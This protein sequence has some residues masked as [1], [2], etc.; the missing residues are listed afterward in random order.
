[1]T[2]T[3]PKIHIIGAGISG[4]IAATVLENKGFSPVVIDSSDRAGGR[5]K[6]D[7]I[8][9]FQLDHGFQVLLSSYSAAQKYLDF[10]SLELQKLK[11]G[12]YIYSDGRKTKYGD[13]LR[14]LSMLVPT[15]FSKVGSFSDKLKIAKLNSDIKK[16]SVEEIFETNE[17]STLDY[18]T[19]YG[20]SNNIIQNFFRP[21]FSGIFLETELETSS[22]M[23]EF[24]FKMFGDG[25][26]VIP[27]AGMEE[28]PKQLKNKLKN[29]SFL[30]N[31]SVTNVKKD[32]LTLSNGQILKSD[33]TIIATEPSNL[34][35]NLQ[36]QKLDW[37]SCQTLYF[38]SKNKPFNTPLIG[39][40][41]K[42]ESLINNI[43]YHTNIEMKNK[44]DMELLSVTVVKKHN[45]SD[46]ELID[47][48]TEE[49]DNECGIKN[50][51][52]LKLYNIP[53]ALPKLNNLQYD[54]SASETKLK[55]GIFLSGDVVLNSS[56][57]AAILSGEKAAIGVI[58]AMENRR[59]FG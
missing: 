19:K 58:E 4:L 59:I 49:L 5:I 25:S 31:T 2:K 54:T 39:L 6:T 51:S 24:V 41:T 42:E 43:F 15:V 11:A 33:Y 1:V 17:V 26:A 7:V 40:I 22:R 28:I 30:F 23:F 38:T 47:Q 57:N 8:N 46:Q 21:F 12:A 9:G 53:R 55:D 27:K 16:K 10:Q 56:L 44:G 29:T 18:L 14:D 13:P 52:F 48:V 36:N 37:K 50:L 3:K 20:F 34:I 45:Y 32:E 35:T